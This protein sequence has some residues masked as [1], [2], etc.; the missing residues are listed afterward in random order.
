M[1]KFTVEK[2]RNYLKTQDSW[3]TPIKRLCENCSKK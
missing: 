1:E 3:D 2:F